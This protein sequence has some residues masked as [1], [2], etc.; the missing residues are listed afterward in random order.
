ME[1]V[2]L[3]KPSKEKRGEMK[4]KTYSFKTALKAATEYFKGDELAD[5]KSVV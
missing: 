1:T 2:V 4:V 3:K 5:R